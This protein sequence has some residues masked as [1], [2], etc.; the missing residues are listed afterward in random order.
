MWESLDSPWHLAEGVQATVA[1][2]LRTGHLVQLWRAG[3]EPHL[4]GWY[5]PAAVLCHRVRAGGGGALLELDDLRFV[6]R[7]D[8]ADGRSLFVYT[9]RDHGTDLLVDA[10]G[11]AHAPVDDPRRRTGHRFDPVADHVAVTE[12]HRPPAAAVTERTVTDGGA[13]VLPFRRRAVDG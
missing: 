5:E 4:H 10:A 9:H 6:G 1:H 8:E 11:V 2:H 7:I 12:L 13:V 3:P